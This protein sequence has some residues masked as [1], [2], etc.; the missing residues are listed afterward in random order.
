MVERAT[1]LFPARHGL[2]SSPQLIVAMAGGPHQQVP[3]PNSKIQTLLETLK[4]KLCSAL[5]LFWTRLAALMSS[6]R[7]P[8][9]SCD[10][11]QVS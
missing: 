8:P 9:S 2:V 5:T 10:S 11:A 7:E 4:E 1:A 3:P 6:S